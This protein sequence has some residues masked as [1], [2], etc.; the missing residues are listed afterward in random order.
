MPTQRVS[1]LLEDKTGRQDGGDSAGFERHYERASLDKGVRDG[2]G[3][4]Q[5][6]LFAFGEIGVEQSTRRARR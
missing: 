2:L 4:V 3:L 6:T 1:L 5:G